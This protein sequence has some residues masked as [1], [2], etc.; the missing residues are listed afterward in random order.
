[1]YRSG[2]ISVLGLEPELLGNVTKS[3]CEAGHMMYIEMESLKK[4]KRVELGASL[5]GG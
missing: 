4:V 5:S 2:L 3:C 1:M